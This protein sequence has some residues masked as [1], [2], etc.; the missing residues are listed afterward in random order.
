METIKKLCRGP[1]MKREE[2][3]ELNVIL[4]CLGR[5]GRIPHL[6]TGADVDE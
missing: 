3:E 2:E 4:K 1:M 5:G 6:I